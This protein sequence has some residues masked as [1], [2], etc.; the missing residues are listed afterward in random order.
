MSATLPAKEEPVAFRKIQMGETY[1]DWD[2]ALRETFKV[3][4]NGKEHDP[5]TM[6]PFNV[7]DFHF[8]EE[9]TD[10]PAKMNRKFLRPY[11]NDP[12]VVNV[13]ER[14]KK[15]ADIGMEK[16]G[17]SM[18]RT[19]VDTVEWLRHAQEE[20]MDLAVYLERVI[21]DLEGKKT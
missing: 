9:L 10:D 20:A 1:I 21:D 3:T 16:Y 19:D 4:I 12:I 8:Q 14:I 13:L 15:R 6:K 2:K 5:V 7:S 17:V 18:A 11:L